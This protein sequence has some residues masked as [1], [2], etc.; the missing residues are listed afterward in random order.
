Y[1][2]SSDFSS[3]HP[4]ATDDRLTIEAV[5]QNIL[6]AE[7]GKESGDSLITD[8]TA[9]R[10]RSQISL[11]PLISLSEIIRQNQIDKIHLLKIDAERSELKIINGIEDAHWPLI[12]QLV[13]EIHDR[14]NC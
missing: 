4:N 13:I 10:L 9:G 8:L 5:A 12:E 3:F 14:T 6:S 2:E 7:A 11:C 1:D